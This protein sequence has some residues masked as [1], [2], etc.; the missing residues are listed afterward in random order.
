MAS[1][2]ITHRTAYATFKKAAV[3]TRELKV[4]AVLSYPVVDLAG[5]FVHADGLNFAIHEAAPWVDL[6]HNGQPVGW[7]RKSLSV[8]GDRYAVRYGTFEVAGT[9][10]RLPVGTSYF[11]PDNRLQSQIFALCERDTLPGVSLE[12]HPVKGYAKAL[13]KSP[14]E[15]R[16]AYEFLKADV[17]RWTHCATPVCQGALTITKSASQDKLASIL[18][19]KR[20]GN[21]QLHPTIYKAL[22]KYLPARKSVVG[23]FDTEKKAMDD[24][25][26]KYDDAIAET[27]APGG[28]DDMTA[29]DDAPPL[30]GVDALYQKV[31]ALLDA[32][33]ALEQDIQSSDSPELRKAAEKFCAKCRAMA[34]EVKSVAD[35][36]DAKLNGNKEASSEE[37]DGDEP[38]GEEAEP[39]MSTD[40]DG[41]LKAVRPCYRKSLKAARVKRFAKADLE[42]AIDT[43]DLE[44]EAAQAEHAAAL[45][46]FRRSQLM[47]GN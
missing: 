7:A 34:E 12:F 9:Q 35:K 18:S 39:D 38:E 20:I 28:D 27:P 37:P 13:G 36:H 41:T 44:L 3:D 23:G 31:Q 4:E 2:A 21:E 42:K 14:L 29:G 30:N 10:H 32:A 24:D 17:V 11:D 46:K 1:Q 5:D 15:N 6:E 19:A 45:K 33:D 16:P 26:T 40:E 22:S 47:A 25:E 43:A 8:A